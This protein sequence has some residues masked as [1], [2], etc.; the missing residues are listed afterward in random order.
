MELE[1]IFISEDSWIFLVKIFHRNNLKPE[2]FQTSW[3][4]LTFLTLSSVSK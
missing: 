1:E 3:K 4:L 2:Y